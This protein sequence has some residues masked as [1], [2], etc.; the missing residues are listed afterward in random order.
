MVTYLIKCMCYISEEGMGTSA[1]DEI[2]RGNKSEATASAL[3]MLG[4]H[5]CD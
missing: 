1:K 4:G 2:G 3:E 5:I